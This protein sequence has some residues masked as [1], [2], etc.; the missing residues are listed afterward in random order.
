MAEAFPAVMKLGFDQ[1]LRFEGEIVDLEVIQGAVP[2]DLHGLYTQA[3]PD[4]QY[5]PI[6]DVLYP[7]DLG[8]GGD[9]M[10]RAFRFAD[11]RA[12]FQ[13]R[14]VKTE[15]FLA[16]RKANRGLFGQY[17]NPF[18]DDPAAVG[19]D[20][21]TANTMINF[22][23]GVLLASK[24]DGI[25]YALDPAT[26]ETLGPWRADGAITSATL[27]AHPK[28]DPATG[29]MF[30]FGYFADGLGSTT[31]QYYVVDAGGK[32]THQASFD[33]PE[34]WMIHDCAITPNYFLLPLMPYS[35]DVNRLK[36]GG[37][38][39]VYEPEGDMIVGVLPRYGKA[40]DI[41]WL[42]GPR[43]VLTHTAN[44]FE[45]DGLIKFDVLRVDGNAFGFV[46][47]D[48]EGR[49]GPFGSAPTALV[50]WTID[51]HAPS[52][53]I[54]DCEVFAT[55]TGEG[56]H[57]DDRWHVKRHRY[58][59]LP[60]LQA[61]GA[62]PAQAAAGDDP[63]ARPIKGP[64]PFQAPPGRFPGA[65]PAKGLPPAP[66]GGK[67][68]HSPTMFNA[69]SLFDLEAGAKQQWFAG[70]GASLQDPVFCPRSADAPEGDGYILVI[71]NHAGVIGGELVILDAQRVA[72]G[73]LA[74]LS[75]PVPLRLGIHATWV[76]GARLPR[77]DP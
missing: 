32:V 1:P 65:L 54:E 10:V 17:R 9:G 55:V 8:A 5:P 19:V 74:V 26:L 38:F 43:C 41:R 62:A 40:E 68:G 59:W 75:V 21:T 56:P 61:D 58:L 50:R 63:L 60:E 37:P 13:T 23:A 29:E 49:G 76:P 15:R 66:P 2:T 69:I 73:P 53:R 24:E 42:R 39:W 34:P 3:V 30:C 28:F 77:R 70:A 36:A 52:G 45:E 46:V 35:T 20:R 47:P 72:D 14:Y 27:T 12:D 6:S 25:S 4:Y 22:H 48:R 18:S 71:R 16:Q 11:G 44:A 57:V 31:V 7:M 64:P 67:P 51:P 33:A